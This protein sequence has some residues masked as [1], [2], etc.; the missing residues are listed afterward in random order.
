MMVLKWMILIPMTSIQLSENGVVMNNKSGL[1]SEEERV[2]IKKGTEAPFSGIYYNHSES[3]LYNCKNCGSPLFRS[4]NKFDSGCG[5]PSF[6]DSIP[7][8][9]LE[10]PDADGRRTEIVCANC[11]GHLGHVFRGEH[12]TPANL[13]H[14]VNSISLNFEPEAKT[15]P[16]R[17]IFASGCFWGTQYHFKRLKGVIS[18]RAGYIGGHLENPDYKKVCNGDTGHVEAV[19]VEYNPVETSYDELVKLYF[20]THDFLQ[21]DGQ[22]PD[23]GSQYLSRIFYTTEAQRETAGRYMQILRDLGHEPVT[24]LLPARTFWPAE[25]YHQDYYEKKGSTPYCHIYRKIF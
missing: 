8:A 21:K 16:E 17:A 2:I 24:I 9:V 20:E 15:Q 12:F 1:T 18:T 19:E 4:E 22:G 23:I 10:K 6:D 11:G 14:C 5:W 25:D 13:R 7:G 3:G